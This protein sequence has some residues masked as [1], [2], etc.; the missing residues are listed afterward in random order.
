MRACTLR[1]ADAS[2]ARS[3]RSG[4]LESRSPRR[5]A[6]DNA[7]LHPDLTWIGV[8][9]R[10]G[11]RDEPMGLASPWPVDQQPTSLCPTFSPPVPSAGVTV[12][13]ADQ[14]LNSR[15][16]SAVRHAG[17]HRHIHCLVD[18]R[19]LGSCAGWRHMQRCGWMSRSLHRIFTKY[20]F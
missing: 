16:F 12:R 10:T 20:K 5:S 9:C 8:C 1:M 18:C 15:G 11:R 6:C 17:T 3:T 19:R 14:Q 13:E 7:K 2:S 4:G